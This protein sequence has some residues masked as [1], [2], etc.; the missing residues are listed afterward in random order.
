[1]AP[2]IVFDG[3]YMA[4]RAFYSTGGLSHGGDAT[5]VAYGI[6]RAVRDYEARWPL[7]QMVFC[8]DHG[9][10]VREEIFPDYKITRRTKKA[11]EMTDPAKRRLLKNFQK[12]V[13]GLKE[14][15]LRKA[16]YRNVFYQEGYEA[17][18]LMAQVVRQLR[19]DNKK[20]LKN[21]PDVYLTTGDHD[22]YQMVSY[23]VAVSHPATG[24]REGRVVRAQE[25]ADQYGVL[26]AEWVRVKAIAGCTSDDIP[27][28]EGVGDKKAAA[29]VKWASEGDARKPCPGVGPDKVNEIL[30]FLCSRTFLRNK[31]LVKLPLPGTEEVKLG[32]DAPNPDAWNRVVYGIGAKSL[33][34]GD[35]ARQSG[36]AVF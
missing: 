34:K 5:G 15:L 13:S 23:K 17:D 1:M 6:L 30:E 24:G 29:F 28:V 22:L 20:D 21:M 36:E 18:D 26:P 9:K 35:K 25:L 12:Q 31:T 7:A 3:N 11:Q 2:V 27:G 19:R 32:K 14:E 33:A 8:F 10:N 16:G 4:Y